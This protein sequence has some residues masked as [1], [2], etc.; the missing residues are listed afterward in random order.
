MDLTFRTSRL[1]RPGETLAGEA[2]HL[3]FGGKGANQAVMASRLGASVALVAAV[4]NDAF[5]RQYVEHLQAQGVDTTH[6]KF[7]G[8][9]TTGVA[10]IIVDD[11]ARNCILVVPG[12]NLSLS[13]DDIHRARANIENAGVLLGQLEVPANTIL[14][15]FRLAKAKGVTTI[16]NPAPALPLLKELWDLCDLCVPNETEIEALT[17]KAADSVDAA[18]AAARELQR[19]GARFVIV[20]LGDRGAVVV[21][22]GVL[23]VPAVPVPAIDPTAAGDAFIGSLAVFWSGGEDLHTAVRKASAVAALTVTR[24]GAQAAF[25]SRA[26][27]EALISHG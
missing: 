1:P 25:P 8:E 18:T 9:P 26:E 4:G 12:A 20:T 16:L 27:V 13:A 7:A 6:V 19:M 10:G 17:G 15:A 24:P 11:E 2:F 23:H 5:G 22:D 21:D 14:E 3:G